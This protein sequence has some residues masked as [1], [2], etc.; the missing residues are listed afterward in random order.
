[1]PEG[2]SRR[3]FIK[4]AA[5]A[6]AAA[7]IPGC[8]PAARK[9]IPYVV[10]DENVTPGMPTY[11][12]TT[13]AECP[14]GCGVIATVREGRVTTLGGNPADPV[15]AGAIC[16]RGQA[17]LQGLYNPDRLTEPMLR[18]EGGAL[19]KISWD[20][21]L[22][23]LTGHLAAAAKAGPNRVAFMGGAQGP[24]FEK[25]ARAFVGAYGSDRAIFYEA[26]STETARS[27]AQTLFGRRDL[28]VYKIDQAET[29]I[30]FGADFMETGP[31]PVELARQYA[32]FRAPKMRRGQLTIGRSFYVGPRMSMTAAKCDDW[33]SVA[34]GAEAQIA[35]SVLHVLVAQR[36]ITQN[37]GL[38]LNA[39]STMVAAYDPAAVSQRTGVAAETITAMG[40]AFGKADG[41]VALA[42]GGEEALHL[43]A[44]ILNAAT[45]NLGRT[46]IYLEGAGAEP[47][48]APGDVNAAMA[49][50]R[51]GKVDVAVLNGANLV[52]TMPPAMR[53]AESLQR[54]AFVA[55]M[56]TVPDETANM[57][58]LLLPAHHPLEAWRD[59]APRPG[60][61]GL[62]QPV[63]QPV[64]QSR[65]ACDIML[66][67]AAKAASKLPWQTAAEAIKA[68]WLALAP[69]GE[70]KDAQ[71][72]FWTTVRREGGLF[73]APK[74][75]SV[76]LSTATLKTPP[77]GDGAPSGLTLVA[78]PHIFLYDGRGAD[79]PWLQEI[80]E[81]VTQIVWDSWA[82]IHPT[83]AAKLG[84]AKDELIEL[85]TEHG[86]IEAPALISTN[87]HPDAIMAP[88]GQGHRAYGRYANGLG[89]NPWQILAE[90][91][92]HLA[93][94]AKAT[95]TSRK[96]VSPLGKSEMLGRSIVE[97]M[98][99]EELRHGGTPEEPLAPGPYEMYPAFPY[100]NHKW[101]MTI[102][103]NACTGCS[104]CV[105]ACYAENNIPFVGKQRVDEGGIMS[106]IRI[107]RYYPED[108]AHAPNLYLAPMLCQQCNHA[109]CEPV[110][111]VFASYHTQEGLNGQIYNRCVGTRYC[112]NNCP[113]KVRRFNWAVPQWPAPLNLQ[114]NPE[115]TVRGAGVMEKCTFC[116]QRI[117]HA[118]INA[119]NDGRAVKDGEIVPACAGACPT[120]AITF[121][122]MNDKQSAMMRRRDDNQP[123]NYR[124]LAELN[125]QPAIV[126]LRDLY[127]VKGKA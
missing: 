37:S 57:A 96:L 5:T 25:I 59:T 78:Y 79:K 108:K 103:V 74:A 4:L 43:A 14:A 11:Y 119:R 64:V 80:P 12:A 63:M 41:A 29:L 35:W 61:R 121:G 36:W 115:V 47:T 124:A 72:D 100:P 99:L 102:D 98:S 7:A 19:R 113:Y 45:G 10:P 112:E 33:V 46:M 52:F 126:Y 123:R 53:A 66:S 51:D 110:C 62:G 125:T 44:Y 15:G 50:M 32:G 34:P 55:W 38:D 82:E 69:Q 91:S 60:V 75:A 70:S 65:A 90:G 2:L 18:G 26:L 85:R 68:Q 92:M 93:V 117:Q 1:M 39:L 71:A 107:E 83:T 8:E 127:R 58:S 54:V 13:C 9:L 27:A 21:A 86:V 101:G 106:W 73:S 94:T 67:A 109:P 89:A 30:S 23:L 49:A 120:R 76:K 111:P 77:P 95:G 17:G 114:L 84:I 81:P 3:S 20:D 24:T 105:A 122:D 31:S 116:V 28:P 6:S 87:V 118:E 40:A 48:T 42:S 97:A 88:L 56:G 16:A 22:G 104:A